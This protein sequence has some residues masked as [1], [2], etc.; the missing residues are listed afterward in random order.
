MTGPVL[1]SIGM[2]GNIEKGL[3]DG[4][5]GRDQAIVSK[6]SVK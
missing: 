2:I 3:S 1:G 6:L 4:M 5:S